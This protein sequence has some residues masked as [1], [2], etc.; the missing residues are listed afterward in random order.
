VRLNRLV[1]RF[2]TGLSVQRRG[3]TY[4]LEVGYSSTDPQKAQRI[5]SAVAEAWLEDHTRR[6]SVTA[7]PGWLGGRI[8]ELRHRLERSERAVGDHKASNSIVNVTQGN[9]LISRQIEDITQIALARS[10]KAEARPARAGEGRDPPTGASGLVSARRR[11]RSAQ[12]AEVA[13]QGPI[14]AP[15]ATAILRSSRSARRRPTCAARSARSPASSTGSG[16]TTRSRRAAGRARD[17]A[18]TLRS[19]ADSRPRPMSG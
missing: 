8:D 7:T 6:S 11:S 16:T 19:R 13:R 9:K 4:I 10:R 17:G 14:S 1:Y 15:S 18:T 2:Q 3:L 12:H 5:S